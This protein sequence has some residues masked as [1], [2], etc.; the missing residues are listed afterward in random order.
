MIREPAPF[1]TVNLFSYT[2]SINFFKNLV[3]HYNSSLI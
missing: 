2:G 3:T 1:Y